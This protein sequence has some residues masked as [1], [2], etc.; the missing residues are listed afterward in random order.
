MIQ[1]HTLCL[2]L[3]CVSARGSDF[4]SDKCGDQFVSDDLASDC[5]RHC[6]SI[7]IF[8]YMNHLFT[9]DGN[10]RLRLAAISSCCQ[11]IKKKAT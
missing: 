1:A 5:G 3:S 7:G 9:F 10:G 2:L 11:N 8:L 6:M 4:V